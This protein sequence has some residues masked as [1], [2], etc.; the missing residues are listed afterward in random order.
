MEHVTQSELNF[1]LQISNFSSTFD[2]CS[3]GCNRIHAM[4]GPG[5]HLLLLLSAHRTVAYKKSAPAHLSAH[6]FQSFLE[7]SKQVIL[8]QTFMCTMVWVEIWPMKSISN[9]KEKYFFSANFSW[10]FWVQVG[11]KRL[12]AGADN[13]NTKM[14]CAV[15]AYPVPYYPGWGSRP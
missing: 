13:S 12:G 10:I 9:S 5:Q 14:L 15:T 3:L 4:C 1:L 7:L 2:Q 8:L 11:K 6:H